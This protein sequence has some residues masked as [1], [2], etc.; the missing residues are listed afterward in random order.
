M[1]DAANKLPRAEFPRPQMRREEKNWK[2]LNG[3]WEFEFDHGNS[4]IA[5]GMFRETANYSHEIIVPFCPESKLSG[6]E[7]KD[8]M[9]C[10]WYRKTVELPDGWDL[11]KGR[12][13]IHFGAV[14]YYAQVWVN[15]EY[16]G[17]HKGGYC[18]F[19][20]DL[21]D[22]L[23]KVLAGDN[24]SGAFRISVRAEDDQNSGAQPSGKQCFEYYSMGCHYTRTTGIWQTVWLEYVPEHYIRSIFITPDVKNEKVSVKLRPGRYL[25]EG[26]EIK[27]TVTDNGGQ[28]FDP[29]RDDNAAGA[30]EKKVLRTV[31][32]KASW[33]ETEIIVPMPGATLWNPCAP[34]LYGLEI[35]LTAPGELTDR[36]TSYFGMRSVELTPDCL[37]VNGKKVFQRLILDQGFYPDGVYTAP[38]DDELRA[39]IERSMAFG[40]NGARLHQKVFEQRFLYWADRLG[41]MCWGEHANWGFDVC[42]PAVRCVYVDEWSEIVERDYSNPSIIGWCPFNETAQADDTVGLIY[43]L[44]K[45]LDPS[46]PVIDTSGWFHH[47]TLDGRTGTDIYDFH[48][49]EQNA[50]VLSGRMKPYREDGV[51]PPHA[52]VTDKR[53]WRPDTPYFCSEFG[54]I[55]WKKDEA[56]GWGY[57]VG[58][59]SA[60]EFIERFGAL[61]S[62]LLADPTLCAFCYTQL[63]DVEQERNGLYTYEREA[64]FPPEVLRKFVAAKAAI[65]E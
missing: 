54:G 17:G 55:M 65:E 33:G 20:L 59:Q 38:T 6:I 24:A 18:S 23:R 12:V 50:S 47:K 21:T 52:P 42:N 22:A 29:D 49:Y 53:A 14:D 61:V 46:R 16:I 28:P 25:A 35:E 48:D 44:T 34:Y 10:V 36:V 37:L 32:A 13:L 11:S 40:F 2:N 41:Y 63:T 39:D 45:R 51:T 43:R 5:R 1:I 26:S 4:G 64:K 3:K 62:I 27:L 8:F 7:Y 15:D 60:D 19:D 31:T 9:R 57:G 30:N 58:P 56:A